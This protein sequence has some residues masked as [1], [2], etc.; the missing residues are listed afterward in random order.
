[1]SSCSAAA[2]AIAI[3]IA[4]GALSIAGSVEARDAAD[5]VTPEARYGQALRRAVAQHWTPPAFD[6]VATCRVRVR[7]LP[8]GEVLDAEPLP[9]CGFD[10]AAQASLVRAVYRADPLP[11]A[12]FE[13]VFARDLTI[14][15][16]APTP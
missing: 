6:T 3:A 10:T 15:F 9:D 14:T 8:G 5:E 7:Q 2:A 1:M 4:G 13:Q 16:T 12:G 11:Y